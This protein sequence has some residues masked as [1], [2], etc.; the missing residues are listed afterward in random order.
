MSEDRELL[1]LAAKAKRGRHGM[2]KSPEHRT[3][4]HMRQRCTNESRRD[5]KFY[6]GRGIK[7]CDRW[8][9]AFLNF[10]A[11]MGPKPSPAHT[12]ERIDG[13]VG[14]E[15]GN[16]RWATQQEQAENTS[17][18]VLLELGG[19][20]Q[21]LTAWARELGMSS[22]TLCR[23][24]ASGWTVHEALTIAPDVANRV[25]P[26]PPRDVSHQPRIGGRFVAANDNVRAAA[27]I[28]RSMK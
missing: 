14:Y 13:N 25:R 5:F 12:I 16:C 24:L 26:E 6:G 8:N 17:A 10:F 21:T 22:S 27:E 28:G 7:V 2:N 3:W 18:T 1:E 9:E 19:K 23:R 11:D 15:P 20:S 4:V